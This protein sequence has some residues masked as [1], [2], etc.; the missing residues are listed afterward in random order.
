MQAPN[1]PVKSFRSDRK[2][3]FEQKDSDKHESPKMDSLKS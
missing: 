3:N 1:I 2:F